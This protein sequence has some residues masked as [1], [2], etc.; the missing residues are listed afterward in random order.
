MR[1]VKQ[2]P[3]F[4]VGVS[5]MINPMERVTVSRTT[6]T[7]LLHR[8]RKGPSNNSSDFQEETGNVDEYEPVE[9]VYKDSSHFLK[10]SSWLISCPIVGVY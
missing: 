4:T 6:Q 1:M 9:E 10:V 2:N 8:F 7:L 5:K 3:L